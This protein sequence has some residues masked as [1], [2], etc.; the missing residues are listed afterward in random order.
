MLN[1]NH[2]ILKGANLTKKEL[3]D[4]DS[5]WKNELKKKN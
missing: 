3:F 1:L 4:F 2:E 5:V